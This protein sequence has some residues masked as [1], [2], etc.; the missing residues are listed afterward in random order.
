MSRARTVAE[1]LE[2]RRLLAAGELVGSFGDGGAIYFDFDDQLVQAA[3]H[4][5]EL[6]D[7]DLLVAGYSLSADATDSREYLARFDA[8]GS[9]DADFG[10]GGILELP[11]FAPAARVTDLAAL[12]D[13]DAL[14]V[15]RAPVD[16]AGVDFLRVAPD[17]TAEDFAFPDGFGDDFARASVGVREG[18][19]AIAGD[20][21]EGG[22]QVFV[23][24]AVLGNQSRNP[25]PY[26]ELPG[27]APGDTVAAV[28]ATAA[29]GPA[30]SPDQVPQRVYL[31]VE[32]RPGGS[33]TATPGVSV[34]RLVPDDDIVPQ[35]LVAD[36]TFGD[37]GVTTVPFGDLAA[38]AV[39]DLD[40]DPLGRVLLTV[41]E[42]DGENRLLRFDADGGLE[43][44]LP[45]RFN[46]PFAFG[47]DNE[48]RR[49]ATLGDGGFVVLGDVQEGGDTDVGAAR[50]TADAQADGDFGNPSGQVRL[51]LGSETDGLFDVA[52]TGDDDLL[53]VGSRRFATPTLAY[54]A[55]LFKLD[56]GEVGDPP[57]VGPPP[58][59][60]A[61][62]D[63]DG[64]LSVVGTDA[65]DTIRVR[66][67]NDGVVGVTRHVD[68]GPSPELVFDVADVAAIRVEAFAG[69]DDVAVS[70]TH[71]SGND[72]PVPSIP[73]TILGGGGDDE[74]RV[75][76]SEAHV[77]EGG[78]GDDVLTSSAGDDLLDGGDGDDT[79]NPGGGDDTVLGGAGDDVF[80]AA[81]VPDGADV[82]DGGDGFD[83]ADYNQR[84]GAVTLTIDGVPDDGA[85]GE[86]DLLGGVEALFGG[87]GDD[88]LSLVGVPADA[89]APDDRGHA[90]FAD[91]R[92]GDDTIVGSPAP[93]SLL[94]G[95][96]DDELDGMAAADTLLGQ[97]G[98][99]TLD[100]GD[101]PDALDGGAGRDLLRGDAGDDTL[102]AGF[103]ADTLEGGAGDDA[104]DGQDGDDTLLPSPGRDA[105]AG[106]GGA[107]LLDL[108]GL[109][110]PV[111]LDRLLD[112]DNLAGG[113][114]GRV[115]A[116]VETVLG[117]PFAD[118][119]L[120][121]DAD[122]TLD[123]NGGDDLLRGRGGDD[124][125]VGGDGF[126]TVDYADRA[127][128]VLIT[129]DNA[130]AVG[131]IDSIDF[132][133][134]EAIVTGNGDDTV[135][136]DFVPD[137]TG[138]RVEAGGGDDSVVGSGG[139]DLLRGGLG[140]DTLVTSA[141]VDTLV[142][143]PGGGM[144]D[145]S[146]ATQAVTLRG[147][148]GPDVL[149]GG[150]GDDALFGLDGDDSLDGGDGDDR[151]Y[152]AS[153]NDTLVGGDGRDS[154][155]AGA[156]ADSLSGGDGNDT[157]LPGD[158]TDEADTVTGG[159][160]GDVLHY[161]ESTAD[162]TIV[163]GEN[164]VG[165][166]VEVALG[167]TGN[168]SI[169]GFL[170]TDGGGGDDT[171]VGDADGPSALLGGDGDDDLRLLAAG[172]LDGGDGADTLLAG[173]GDDTLAADR[174]DTLD[175]GG[176]ENDL[177]FPRLAD[178]VTVDL[179][180]VS[181]VLDGPG[182]VAGAYANVL[183]TAGDDAITGDD[184]RNW[185]GGGEGDDTL[186]GNGG[187]DVLVG[188]PGDDRLDAGDGN[189]L[190]LAHAG[191]RDTLLG[192]G[193][194]DLALL[195]DDD[196]DARDG[197]ERTFRD[198]DD[199]MDALA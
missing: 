166:D 81:G 160:G 142:A 148:D 120:G 86:G 159:D 10:D 42:D 22:G 49:G 171:L 172:F 170:R 130:G 76:G 72:A 109:D 27:F 107:D 77:L 106:G 83:T 21:G 186:V 168:D 141:G 39:S 2:A 100:G 71:V 16:G 12:P 127:A 149:I 26:A 64:L 20:D 150:A 31:A 53:G 60:F 70:S 84:A 104:L 14:A 75:N 97:D 177:F 73:A 151:L 25:T 154:L 92:G 138:Y 1:R 8:D 185:L 199:L 50:F 17:G 189:D 164:G 35:R 96:G 4:V 195:G 37:G 173:D 187:G 163:R 23:F 112:G 183:G 176:G 15:R 30:G 137:P 125:L 56:L 152:G 192:G 36:P 3:T 59:D 6:T 98:D 144:L 103:D 69:S 34:V 9:L 88:L 143:G 46:A 124:R 32:S 194:D 162:L 193:G 156:G 114:V 54:D 61:T 191:G 158:S 110:A 115:E 45:F 169:R 78:A 66:L 136:L 190:L 167:G 94:G 155:R 198:L 140:A 180:Q 24:G 38:F 91:G 99:D 89:P 87:N 63:D 67:G 82:F 181:D 153:G 134:I 175:A 90:A 123:G 102:A 135:R 41:N 51:D 129:A 165:D 62:L 47:A 147:G 11:D 161:R 93:D 29:D 118:T 122:D 128:P 7:G 19:V 95:E 126:D 28:D 113:G 48:A 79:L 40:L 44:D 74:L 133:T 68:G 65:D 132:A 174:Q 117:T 157:L 179:R 139:D 85:E 188:G 33:P 146:N 184:A 57:D 5:V 145:A 105:Y 111:S 52:P 131:E 18:R 13:G 43:L 182:V 80:V 119:L 197:V 178:G 58:P 196:D 108:S 55:A 116:G 121:S 101:G